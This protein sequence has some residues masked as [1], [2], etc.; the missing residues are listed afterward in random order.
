MAK[1]LNKTVGA[2][3]NQETKGSEGLETGFCY[4]AAEGHMGCVLPAS[5]NVG[6]GGRMRRTVGEIQTHLL[7]TKRTQDQLPYGERE[8][9][10]T[11]LGV[12][13]F[14]SYSL[15]S[16]TPTQRS[17]PAQSEAQYPCDTGDKAQT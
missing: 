15:T 7:P 4:Q 11:H 2:G 16:V 5:P 13:L 9:G 14:P 6:C 3:T 8:D 10:N 12:K 17:Y 1:K